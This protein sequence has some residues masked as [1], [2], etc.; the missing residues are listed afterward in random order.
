MNGANWST[1][2]RV[3]CTTFCSSSPPRALNKQTPNHN[4]DINVIM[5]TMDGLAP[6]ADHAVLLENEGRLFQMAGH[7][8]RTDEQQCLLMK[9][10][11]TVGQT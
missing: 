9:T 5:S 1:I 8:M 11:L 4:Q 2:T 7:N 3:P 10:V 6:P